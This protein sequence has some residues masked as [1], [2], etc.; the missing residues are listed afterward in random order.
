MYLGG[1]IGHHIGG[2][3]AV[4]GPG[5]SGGEVDRAA[6]SLGSRRAGPQPADEGYTLIG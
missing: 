1:D 5:P 6:A 2:G 3:L 4:Y